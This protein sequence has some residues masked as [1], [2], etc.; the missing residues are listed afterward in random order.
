MRVSSASPVSGSD[1]PQDLEQ[2]G[3]ARRRGQALGDVDEQPPAGLAIGRAAV[4]C[5]REIPSGFIASVI[6]CW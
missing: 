4:S 5:H 6:I 3:T 1:S 2:A